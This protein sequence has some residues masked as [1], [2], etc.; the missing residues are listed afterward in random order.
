M[1][2]RCNKTN[3]HYND[4]YSCKAKEIHVGEKITCRTYQNEPN[5]VRPAKISNTMFEQAPEI[6]PFRAKENVKVECHAKCLFNKDG[7]CK[8]NGI[9]VLD[10][11]KDGI[12]GTF[13]EE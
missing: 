2:L 6:A 12:C 9:T 7:L 4:R 5:K 11:K 10:G 13:I 1:D 8:A 3:C